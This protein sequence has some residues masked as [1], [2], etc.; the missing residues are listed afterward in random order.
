MLEQLVECNYPIHECSLNFLSVPTMRH[1]PQSVCG[2]YY[3]R[4]WNSEGHMTSPALSDVPQKRIVA[5]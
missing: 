1:F 3:D 5:Y 2:I 4:R